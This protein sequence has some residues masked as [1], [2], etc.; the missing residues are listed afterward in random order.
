MHGGGG[1]D[2]CGGQG[3]GCTTV[4]CMGGGGGSGCRGQ[5]CGCATVCSHLMSFCQNANLN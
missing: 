4:R 1:V 3:C 2:G 5:V